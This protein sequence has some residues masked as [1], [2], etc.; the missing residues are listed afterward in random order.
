M[1]GLAGSRLA[2]RVGFQQP[3]FLRRLGDSGSKMADADP[4]TLSDD[5][6]YPRWVPMVP[7]ARL[8]LATPCV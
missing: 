2:K 1:Y 5:L 7:G 6:V 3:V 4:E 8:E